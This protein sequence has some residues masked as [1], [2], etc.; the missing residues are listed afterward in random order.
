MVLC[1]IVVE[2]TRTESTGSKL[3]PQELSD[4]SRFTTH[5]KQSVVVGIVSTSLSAKVTVQELQSTEI[6]ETVQ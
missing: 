5:L 2:L 1:R 3:T 6:G 4:I